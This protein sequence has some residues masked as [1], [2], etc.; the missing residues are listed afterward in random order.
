MPPASEKAIWAQTAAIQQE[1]DLMY[2]CCN[3]T[4][5]F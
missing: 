2:V 5:R 3:K 4:K 1:S